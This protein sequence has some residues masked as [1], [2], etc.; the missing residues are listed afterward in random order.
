M[1]QIVAQA[2]ILVRPLGV[3]FGPLGLGVAFML[4]RQDGTGGGAD[5]AALLLVGLG[6]WGRRRGGSIALRQ[7]GRGDGKNGCREGETNQ[8]DKY[9]QLS[10][11]SYLCCDAEQVDS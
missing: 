10:Q 4:T 7:D 1:R 2:V 3:N 8:H 9:L 11:R 5:A 6:L